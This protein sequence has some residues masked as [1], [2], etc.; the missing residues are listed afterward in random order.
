MINEIMKILEKKQMIPSKYRITLPRVPKSSKKIKYS[1]IASDVEDA[2][3]MLKMSPIDWTKT[4]YQTL[5][6]F[7]ASFI[8]SDRIEKYL[9]DIDQKYKDYMDEFKEPTTV[10]TY[11]DN[12]R[13]MFKHVSIALNSLSRIDRD[14]PLKKLPKMAGKK[15]RWVRSTVGPKEVIKSIVDAA[16]TKLPVD[17]SEKEI[18]HIGM[19]LSLI[20]TKKRLEKELKE[21]KAI[22]VA[23]NRVGGW[24]GFKKKEYHMKNARNGIEVFNIALSRLYRKKH[25]MIDN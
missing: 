1:E 15:K 6:I 10:K 12:L 18:I 11:F 8:K 13:H 4:E 21:F 14:M 25:S 19:Y 9:S 2:K 16:M 7:I 17:L 20:Y 23:S 22:K 5:S 3:A 24:A